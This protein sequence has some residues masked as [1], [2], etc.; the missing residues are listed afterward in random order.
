MGIAPDATYSR[1]Q[2]TASHFLEESL[3]DGTRFVN[4]ELFV[5]KYSS[6]F[7]IDYILGYLTHLIADDIWLKQIYFKNNFKKRIDADPSLLERWHNDFRKLNGKLIEWFNYIGLKNELESS[8]V[9]VTNIQEIKYEN[10]QKFKEETLLDFCYSAEDLNE[11][12]E[13]YTFEQILEYIDLAVNA[14]LENDKLINLIERRNC[15]SGKEILSVFRNDLSNYSPAQLTHIHEQGVWSIGQMYDHIILVAHEYL[16]NAEACARLTKEQPLGK[17][18]MGEQLMKDGG[19]PPVKIRLPDEMNTP[20]NNT[21]SKEV[22]TNRIDKV[23]ERL[24]QWEVDIDLVNPNY[25][26]EHGGFG[27]LNAKEWI[28][29]VEM[30]SRHHLRQQKELERYI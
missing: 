30:H 25:K 17:T 28:E 18:Q 21:D 10:L 27:W 12:L 3:E 2:K 6:H 20:P 14:V 26:I 29:L 11:E 15:M 9:P 8:R 7:Q 24:E 22:L 1:E 16:D 5:K 19:F 4:Y 23:I 13:V